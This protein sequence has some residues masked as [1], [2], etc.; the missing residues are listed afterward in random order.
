MLV[1]EMHF[2]TVSEVSLPMIFTCPLPQPYHCGCGF[3]E[4]APNEVVNEGKS[5]VGRSD[6]YV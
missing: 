5:V 1:A 4:Q 3:L 2:D 6:G